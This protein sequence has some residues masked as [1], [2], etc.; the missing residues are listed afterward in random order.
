MGR[1]DQRHGQRLAGRVPVAARGDETDA[2][3]ARPDRLEPAGVGTLGV[4]L[5]RDETLRRPVPLAFGERRVAP[6]E[7]ALLP[8]DPAVHAGFARRV[9]LGEFRR[10]DAEALLQ[11]ER[12]KRVE[13]DLA[14]AVIRPRLQQ[15]AAQRDVV[16]VAAVDLVAQLAADAHPCDARA[17]HAD[18]ELAHAH[19][20]QGGDVALGQALDDL[21]RVGTGER[22]AA[23]LL[24]QV[25][26]RDALFEVVVEPAHV[27]RP[28][29]V[30]A[31]DPER[32]VAPV[33]DG[34]IALEAAV[35]GQ[36]RRKP[37]TPRFGQFRGH[38]PVQ[39]R[40]GPR[41]RDLVAREGRDIEKPHGLARGAAFLGDDRMRVG[42]LQRRRFLE[43][44]GREVERNL[45]V[46]AGAPDGPRR[47]HVAIGGRAFEGAACGQLLVGVGHH[48]AAGIELARCL[49]DIPL[50]LG[51]AAIARHVHAPGVGL[52]LAVDHPFGQRLAHAAPLQEARHH[53]AGR[54]VA[55]L[56]RHRADQRV[57]VGREGE[58]AV[59]PGLDARVL[60][61]GVA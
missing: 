19:E 11:P 47:V 3:L 61:G 53:R 36:H 6:D 48:E 27:P 58:G 51:P 4:D 37:R 22:E 16:A 52:G 8:V 34:Q 14:D 13:A 35:G 42:A 56:A 15:R 32:A 43:P 21:E 38:E 57:A 44:L 28:Q 39:P 12:E 40:L 9:A 41:P 46:P 5:E 23:D 25:A 60:G 54:P 31:H 7:I 18:V 26:H 20:G 33:E 59:H 29:V 49:P 55:A 1:I 2:G 45:H 17:D 30:G 24:A 50:V 10:P